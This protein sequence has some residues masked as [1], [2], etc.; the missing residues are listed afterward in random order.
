MASFSNGKDDFVVL[1]VWG[2]DF[3]Y[4]P[5]QNASGKMFMNTVDSRRE[6]VERCVDMVEYCRNQSYY[7]NK[8]CF[9]QQH[10]EVWWFVPT[11]ISSLP[12][13]E[14]IVKHFYPFYDELAFHYTNLAWAAG[15]AQ[16]WWPLPRYEDYKQEWYVKWLGKE[17]YTNWT[18]DIQKMYGMRMTTDSM[19]PE[20]VTAT[21]AR[22]EGTDNNHED[23]RITEAIE[24]NTGNGI[25]VVPENLERETAQAQE[26]LIGLRDA[27]GDKYNLTNPDEI[28]QVFREAATLVN[29]A[30]WKEKSLIWAEDIDQATRWAKEAEI[31]LRD[32]RN[33][34]HKDI[35]K[36]L[37]TEKRAETISSKEYKQLKQVMKDATEVLD[38]LKDDIKNMRKNF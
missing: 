10:W 7:T 34:L 16:S 33:G 31:M 8:Q 37:L 3:M 1:G 23:E 4:H 12:R 26:L 32:A 15:N 21:E 9:E 20:Y 14:Y 5:G 17:Q 13:Q 19:S 11:W 30:Q 35:N 38:R 22:A 25:V 2:S 27:W 6:E 36:L 18:E 29:K 28:S 24:Q